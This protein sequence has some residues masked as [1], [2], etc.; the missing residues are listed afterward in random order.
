MCVDIHARVNAPHTCVEHTPL[1]IATKTLL[2]HQSSRDLGNNASQS[3]ARER[4]DRVPRECARECYLEGE[5][6]VPFLLDKLPQCR[7]QQPEVGRL[8]SWLSGAFIVKNRFHFRSCTFEK[9]HSDS[10]KTSSQ[11][12]GVLNWNRTCGCKRSTSCRNLSAANISQRLEPRS[13]VET[14]SGMTHLSVLLT[15]LLAFNPALRLNPGNA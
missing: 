13:Q 15:V 9:A 8:G 7:R 12:H 5:V 3:A 1:C 10:T 14:Y 11:R 4:T 2:K 6:A